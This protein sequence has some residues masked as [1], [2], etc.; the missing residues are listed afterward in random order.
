M[1]ILTVRSGLLDL[2]V[3]LHVLASR[4]RCVS[5]NENVMRRKRTTL[6]ENSFPA[7]TKDFLRR[8]CSRMCECASNTSSIVLEILETVNQGLRQLPIVPIKTETGDLYA[9]PG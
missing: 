2:R 7:D 9:P 6:Y 3:Y 8:F 1:L 5:I 4:S